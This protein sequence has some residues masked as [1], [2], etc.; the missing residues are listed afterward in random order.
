ML[1]AGESYQADLRYD[2]RT[3]SLWRVFKNNKTRRIGAR[4]VVQKM[5]SYDIYRAPVV[6]GGERRLVTEQA[7]YPQEA[8]RSALVKRFT[9]YPDIDYQGDYLVIRTYVG[10]DDE[11]AHVLWKFHVN[12]IELSKV[13][14]DIA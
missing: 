6:P 14:V 3:T 2:A 8:L 10:Q 12:G 7:W 5:H 13:V 11:H 1:A 4:K 9:Q